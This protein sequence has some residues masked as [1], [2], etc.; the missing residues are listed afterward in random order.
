MKPS[1]SPP[2][3]FI[4]FP[5]YLTSVYFF[6]AVIFFSTMMAVMFTF[7]GTVQFVQYVVPDRIAEKSGLDTLLEGLFFGHSVHSTYRIQ[8]SPIKGVL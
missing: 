6:P 7:A 4:G 8:Q 5:H 2:P 3:I 1:K